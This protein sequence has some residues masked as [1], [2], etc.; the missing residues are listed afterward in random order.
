[1]CYDCILCV[2][3]FLDK[4]DIS[5]PGPGYPASSFDRLFEFFSLC[6]MSVFFLC[7]FFFYVLDF[8][9]DIGIFPQGPG[10]STSSFDPLFEFC[11]L[12]FFLLIFSMC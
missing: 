5:L 12:C 2:R 10:C 6:L 7:V 9:V 11:V 8:L 4:I 1:M 3:Y